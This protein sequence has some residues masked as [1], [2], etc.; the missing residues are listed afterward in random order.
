MM[1]MMH[2]ALNTQQLLPC[3]HFFWMLDGE[4]YR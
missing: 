2:D 4:V 1:H 3:R